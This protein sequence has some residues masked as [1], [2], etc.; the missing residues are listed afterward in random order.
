M[1]RTQE[2]DYRRDRYQRRLS[3][4]RDKRSF[5]RCEGN[6]KREDRDQPRHEFKR[7]TSQRRS[8]TPRNQSFF[9]GHCFSCNNFGHKVVYSRAYGRNG[10]A[11]NAYVTLYNIKC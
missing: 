8:F 11:I 10:Q 9:Y 6:D 5:N 2:E 4:F 1:K 7:T 3:T